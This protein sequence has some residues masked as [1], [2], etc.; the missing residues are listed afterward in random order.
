VC[1]GYTLQGGSWAAECCID[2][3]KQRLGQH[4]NDWDA[5]LAY[6]MCILQ[7][8]GDEQKLNFPGESQARMAAA[9]QEDA[10]RM[11]ARKAAVADAT[12]P[13]EQLSS[14]QMESFPPPSHEAER[15]HEPRVLQQQ[16]PL[17]MPL[18]LPLPFPSQQQQQQ[19]QHEHP[20]PQWQKK[21][22]LVTENGVSS[23]EVSLTPDQLTLNRN[24]NTSQLLLPAESTAAS[25]ISDSGTLEIDI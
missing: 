8:G 25:C 18:P 23:D 4:Q 15:R 5:A 22:K 17:P 13:R 10:H 2:G 9:A 24:G 20:N 16:P 14:T 12:K 21:E 11:R 3:K 1:A 6:D 19:Q 7:R